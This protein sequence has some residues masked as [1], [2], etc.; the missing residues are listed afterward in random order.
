M[1]VTIENLKKGDEVLVNGHNFRY[2]KLLREPKKRTKPNIY[3]GIN[4]YKTIKCLE[5]Y[6]PL[7]GS[8][9]FNKEIYYD[10]NCGH[11]WLVKREED[12][13]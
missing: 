10:F 12:G 9:K 5:Q 2:L 8:P 4:G 3:H 1:R 6:E 13:N 7:G 11:I